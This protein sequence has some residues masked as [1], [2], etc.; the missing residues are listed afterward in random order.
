MSR[1]FNASGSNKNIATVIWYLT[2]L[3][4]RNEFNPQ[5]IVYPTVMDSPNNVETDDIKRQL[6]LEYILDSSTHQLILSSIGF[7]PSEFENKNINLIVLENDK[8]SLLI[9]EDYKKYYDFM[10]KLCDAE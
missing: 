6:L 9:E 2:V 7:E 8:Y 10:T 3:T 4:L 5:A 1:N